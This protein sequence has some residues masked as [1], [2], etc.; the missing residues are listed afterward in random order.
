M[1]RGMDS[2]SAGKSIEKLARSQDVDMDAPF[3]G[4]K[5]PHVAGHDRVD[6]SGDGNFD[7]R[8]VPFI[9]ELERERDADHVL[10][11]VRQRKELRDISGCQLQLR[12]AQN[13]A[14]LTNDSSIDNDRHVAGQTEVE[15]LRGR[16]VISEQ[17][18]HDDIGVEYDPHRRSTA[19]G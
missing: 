2:A 9:R 1:G 17:P 15:Y 8:H 3:P 12:A 6:G 18:G 19:A 16:S 10:G 13:L 5:M 4:A 7:E 14:I 11:I